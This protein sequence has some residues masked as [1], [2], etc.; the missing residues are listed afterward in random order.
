MRAN[1]DIDRNANVIR[2]RL[3]R[4]ADA[5]AALSSL[6]NSPIVPHNTPA[7]KI[8]IIALIFGLE[9]SDCLQKLHNFA[10]ILEPVA[11]NSSADIYGVR[12]RSDR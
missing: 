1:T 3:I 6:T 5:P 4:G 9:V 2:I 12:C 10:V 11:L 8:Y 7:K